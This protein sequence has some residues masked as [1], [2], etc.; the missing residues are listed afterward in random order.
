MMAFQLAQPQ[1]SVSAF[2]RGNFDCV[3]IIAEAGGDVNKEDGEDEVTPL[4]M[5]VRRA[6]SICEAFDQGR[7]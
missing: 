7:R 4:E 3:K 6:T 5:A 1:R 2:Q